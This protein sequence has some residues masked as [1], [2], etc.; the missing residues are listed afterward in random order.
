MRQDVPVP[1]ATFDERLD[2]EVDGLAWIHRAPV[3]E[4]IDSMIVWLPEHRDRLH[5]QP[6][7]PA[8]PALPQSQYPAG[9]PLPAGGAVPE[10]VAGC[11]TLQPECL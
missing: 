5:Q 3:G 8:V 9:R 10:A 7:G 6:A 2:L 4:T 1:D 11:A